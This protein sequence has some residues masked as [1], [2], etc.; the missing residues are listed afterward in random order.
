MTTYEV[1]YY[2]NGCYA[3]IR[4]RWPRKKVSQPVQVVLPLRF[5][6][7]IQY[8]SRFPSSTLIGWKKWETLTVQCADEMYVQYYAELEG[9]T[10]SWRQIGGRRRVVSDVFLRKYGPSEGW[11]GLN[12]LSTPRPHRPCNRGEPPFSGV[13]TNESDLFV[14]AFALIL[15]WV[16]I[17]AATTTF[18]LVHASNQFFG[19]KPNKTWFVQGSN[20]TSTLPSK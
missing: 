11:L 1:L 7:R 5:V 18:D 16:T 12:P 10:Q 17:S 9:P 8:R 3:N 4:S 19:D 20:T 15:M 14:Q 6:L 13:F 2:L